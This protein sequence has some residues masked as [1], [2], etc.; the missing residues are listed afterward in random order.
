MQAKYKY[1][2]ERDANNDGAHPGMNAPVK[3]SEIDR[4]LLKLV[5]RQV[6]L[7]FDSVLR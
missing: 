7:G 1:Y 2:T 6:S 4:F 5:V 3:I